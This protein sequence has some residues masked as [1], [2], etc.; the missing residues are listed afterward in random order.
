MDGRVS[1]MQNCKAILQSKKNPWMD[2]FLAG[3][4][5]AWRGGVAVAIAMEG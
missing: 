5:P 1:N 2:F 3:I 4:R